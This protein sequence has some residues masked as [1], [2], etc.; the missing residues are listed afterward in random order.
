M[1]Y[2]LYTLLFIFVTGSTLTAQEKWDLRKIVDYAMANNITVKQSEVQANVANLVYNQSKTA[3]LPTVSFSGNEGFYS[4]RNQDPTTFRLTT[5]SYWSAGL[6]LQSSAD[7]F[8]FFS[9]KNLTLSNE[10]NCR[11]RGRTLTNLKTTSP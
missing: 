6:Q 2:F 7:I 8:N 10:W 1:R 3:M 11:Q 5:Q 9:K 4:G